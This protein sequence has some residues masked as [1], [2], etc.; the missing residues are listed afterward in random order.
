MRHVLF[1]LA[2]GALFTVALAGCVDTSTEASAS[3]HR[4]TPH[5]TGVGTGVFGFANFTQQGDQVHIRVEV[6]GLSAIDGFEPGP[7]GTHIHAG[8]ECGPTFQ[9]GVTTPGGRALGHFNPDNES[10]PHHAGDLGNMM[11]D[12][13]GHGMLE[14]TV[15]NIDLARTESHNVIGRTVVIHAGEDDLES[16]P[17]G[18]AGPRMLCGVIRLVS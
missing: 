9:D 3:L 6:W 4:V 17:A 16:Q 18:D 5:G 14:V 12:D 11:V 10:H 13:D 2:L 8:T 7:K 1:L 15:S